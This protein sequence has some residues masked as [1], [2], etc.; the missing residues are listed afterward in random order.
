MKV[1]KCLGCDAEI[2]WAKQKAHPGNPHPALAPINPIPVVGGNLFLSP[3]LES[4]EVVTGELKV[5]AEKRKMPLYINHLAY[6]P[7]KEEFGKIKERSL[8]K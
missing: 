5:I 4:Y 2:L 6:C 7:K 3:D 8:T 1:G